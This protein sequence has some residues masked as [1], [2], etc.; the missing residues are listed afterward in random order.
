VGLIEPEKTGFGH[1]FYTL[2]KTGLPV[3][4]RDIHRFWTRI[5]AGWLAGTVENPV[6]GKVHTDPL[7]TASAA[8]RAIFDG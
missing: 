7:A 5:R 8:V 2:S 6:A 4:I 1:L 3:P